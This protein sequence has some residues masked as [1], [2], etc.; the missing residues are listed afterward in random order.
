M[1]INNLSL[2]QGVACYYSSFINVAKFHNENMMGEDYLFLSEEGMALQTNIDDIHSLKDVVISNNL[3]KLIKT[4]LEKY[5]IKN[6]YNQFSEFP[7]FLEYIFN[8]V[9][10]SNPIIIMTNSDLLS[11]DQSYNYNKRRTHIL[12]VHGFDVKMGILHFI[13]YFIPTFPA[14]IYNGCM[15]I[16]ALKSTALIN[17]NLYYAFYFDIPKLKKNNFSYSTTDYIHDLKKCVDIYMSELSKMRGIS[18]LVNNAMERFGEND[19]KNH[20]QEVVYNIMY[21]SII[22]CRTI[23]KNIC[24]NNDWLDSRDKFDKIISEWYS[25]SLALIKCGIVPKDIKFEKISEKINTLIDREKE[26]MSVLR[27]KDVMHDSN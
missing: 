2:D 14:K 21:N 12:V 16:N 5:S 3:N 22:P 10:K 15:S 18:F 6:E 23:L 8:E 9:H 7:L 17:D 13:D 27:G 4:F 1:K 11:H 24:N 20:L 19:I 26:V 25:I